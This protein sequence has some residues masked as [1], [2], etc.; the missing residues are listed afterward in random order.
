MFRAFLHLTREE[1]E[2]MTMD[3]YCDY[4]VVL[5]SALKLMHAPFMPHDE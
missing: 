4:L 5:E 1:C 3:L 2:T